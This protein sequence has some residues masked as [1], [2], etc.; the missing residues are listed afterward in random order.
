MK[1]R[2]LFLFLTIICI[3]FSS[4]FSEDDTCPSGMRKTYVDDLN[5]NSYGSARRWLAATCFFQF[6]G[7]LFFS[8]KVLIEPRFEVHYKTAIDAVEIVENS[9]EQKIYGF[10][11]VI[12]GYKNTISGLEA[13]SVAGGT[14]SS[15]KF[16]D[17]GYNNFVNALIIE[18]D[19]NPDDY[20]PGD[21]SFS[22]RYCGTSC[23]SYDSIAQVSKKLTTQAY[24]PGQ[25]NEWD[26]RLVYKEKTLILY[27][28]PNNVLHQMSYDLEAT[29]G[30]NIGYV[31]FT[32]F[33]ESNRGEVNI[34]GTF[35]CED[36]YVIS[37]M[38]GTFYQNGNFY[39]EANY[40][41]GQTINYAFN[42]IDNQ[43][44]KV[45]HTFGY[46]IWEY[47]FY[48]TQDCD[49]KGSYTISK[50]DN[51]TLILTIPACT[52]VGSHSININEDIKGAAPKSYYN[53]VPGPTKQIRLVGHDG[54]IGAVPMK[55]STDIYYLGFGES[56]SGDF[57]IKKD[58]K[59]ILDFQIS[60]QYGNK[61]IISSSDNLFTLK[62]V[63]SD[64]ST[65]NI[66]ANT[67]SYELKE[68]G[69][70]YQMTISVG[71]IG[72]YQ[73]EK[74]EYMDKPIRFDVIP[75]DAS[76]VNSYCELTGYSSAPTVKVGTTLTYRC[77]LRDA[78]GNEISIDSFIQNSKYEFTCSVDKN[79]P[80]QKAFSPAIFSSQSS[81]YDCQYV[82]SEI[83]NFAFNG[84]LKL[85]TTKVT[86]KITSIINQF[87]V[88]GESSKYIIQKILDPSTKNWIDIDTRT[89][90]ITYVPD[91]KGFITAIDFA[92]EDGSVLISSYGSYPSDFN[93]K[94]IA[95]KF[96][97][98]HDESFNFVQPKLKMITLD[99]KP[100]IGVYTKDETSTDLLFKKTSFY[101]NL[102][103]TYNNN[104]KSSA[105]KYI[106]NLSN[107]VTCF[108]N[109]KEENTKV[110]IPDSVTLLTKAKESKIGYLILQTTDNN[111]YNY[112]I[113]KENIK[114]NLKP[115][116][117]N[118]IFRI[119][120]QSTEGVYDIY[121]QSTIDFIGEFEILVNE[122]KVKTI[123]IVSEPPQ[124]C[125]LEWEN[126]KNTIQQ[127]ETIGKEKY[128]EYVGGFDNGN[129]V[130][131]FKLY[132]KYNQIIENK[133]YFSKYADISSEKYGSDTTYFSI[134]YDE[135]DK[136][137]KF[138]DNVPYEKIQQGWIFYTRE[139]TCNNKYYLRYDGS[140]GGSPLSLENSYFTLLNTEIYINYEAFV[141][142]IYKDQNNQL[143]G[144]QGDKLDLAKEKTK[145]TAK[146]EENYEITLNYDTTTSNYA[147]R[148]KAKFTVSGLYKITVKYD[149]TNELKYENS[150]ELNVIDNIYN[151][152]HSKFKMIIGTVVEMSIDTRVTLDNK[153]Y[154]PNFKLEFYSKDDLKTKYDKNIKFELEFKSDTMPQPIIFQVN[155]NNDEFVQFNFPESETD[156]FK[157]LT[158]GDYN[159]ILRD[160]KSNL[161]YPISL[162]GGVD[163]DHSNDKE[164][165]LS[166]TEVRPLSIDGIAGKTYT[167]TIEFRAKDNLRWNYLV[168]LD[169][170]KIEYS[171][172]DLTNEN[173]N[174]KHILGPKKGQVEILVTQ[175]K[176]TT[177][178]PNYLSFKYKNEVIPKKVALTI[179][180]ADLA[181]LELVEGPTAG[182]VIDP[183]IIV[184]R[185][186]DSYGNLYEN[187]FTKSVSKEEL[188]ALTVGTSKDKISLGSNH[189]LKDNEFLVV[190]YTSQVS[191]N[192]IVSSDYFENS[193]TYE[194]RIYSGPIDKDISYAE[195]KST[196][197]DVGGEYILLITPKDLY[198]NDIDGLNEAHLS[199]FAIYYQTIT[200]TFKEKVENCTLVEKSTNND[201]RIL[202]QEEEE[203]IKY[204]NIECRANITKAGMFQFVVYYT[205]F[206][207]SCK[208][209]CQFFVTARDVW[210]SK[211][212]T[213]Y[214]NKNIYLK[215]EEDNE[216]ETETYPV[217]EVSFHDYY[218]NQLE[219]F[220]VN[221][222]NIGAVL[223]GTDIK[224]CVLDEGGKTK[225]IIVCPT[226]NGDDNENKWKYLTNNNYKLMIYEINVQENRLSYPIAIRDGSPDGSSDDPDFTKTYF[227]PKILNLIAGEEG[228]ILMEI[229]TKF[230]QRKN[231][232]YPE[233][234]GKIKINFET[235]SNT[236]SSN[237][238][239]AELPGQ[240]YIKITCTKTTNSNYISVF[241]E[242]QKVP[243]KI[244]LV[245]N[246]GLA[247]YLELENSA[248]FTISSD[249]YT[250]KKN[251]TND[252]IVSFS[253]KFKD[254]YQNYLTN[255]I[256]G[257]NQY[258][259]FSET[260]GSG[261]TYYDLK[262]DQSK[263]NY[264][265][266]DKI[267][268]V[269]SKHTWN[270]YIVE[271][272]RKY[273][274]IYTKVPGVPDLSKSYWKIDKTSY[275]LKETSIVT[276]Y[277]IDRLGV[278][279]GSL[280]NNLDNEKDKVSVKT[281]KGNDIASYTYNSFT[282]EY[283]KYTYTYQNIGNYEV[284]VTYNN[285]NMQEKKD[286][287]VAYQKVDLKT[288][289]LYY[290]ID[291]VN[292]NLM[293]LTA[294]TNINNILYYPFYKFFLY[295]SDGEKITLYDKSVKTTCVMTYSTYT[296]E[297]IVE[298]LDDYIKLSYKPDFREEFS[299]LPLAAYNLEITYGNEILK[300]PLFLLGE[301]D[302][303]PS[304][305]YDLGKI[306]INPIE[307]EAY[308][309]EE[310]EVDIEFR[311][312]DGLRWNYEI[313]LVSFGV[314]NSYNL[315]ETKLQIKK[316][317]GEKNGLMKLKIKQFVTTTGKE[318]NILTL[319]YQ[320]KTITQ[321]I[322]LN[323]KSASLKYI[324][325]SSGLKDG[326][327]INPPILAFIPYDEFGNICTQV[328]DKNEYP[329]NK[330]NALFKGESKE[331]YSLTSNIYTDNAYIYVSYGCTKVTKIDVTSTYF[332]QTY[333]YQ[334]FSG[335]IDS[336]TSYAEIVKI[337]NVIAGDINNIK[338]YPKDKY[339]NDVSSLSDDE[340]SNFEV[341]YTIGGGDSITISGNC[342]KIEGKPIYISCEKNITKSG[343]V[344]FGVDYSDKVVNCINCQFDINP[345]ALDFLKTKVI[346]KN[347][348]K[349]MSKTNI[350]VLSVTINP[351]FVLSFFDRFMNSIINENEV[352]NLGVNT[353]IEITDVKLCVK[354]D[355]L[356]KLSALCDS[357][358]NDENIEK[359]KYVPNGNN[360]KL[361]VYTKTQNLI[362]PVQ[363][364]GG[365]TDGGSGPFDITKTYINPTTLTLTAGVEGSVS[366]ELRTKDNVRKNYWYLDI[367]SHLGVKFPD[368][369]EQCEYTIAQGSKP[370]QYTFKFICT[371]KK[372]SFLTT[373]MV[374][375]QEIPT[376]ITM[377]VIPNE[378]TWSKLFTMEGNEI[379]QRN[380]GSV[381]V[382]DKFQMIN[383]LYDKYNN[384]ITD[385]NFD[386]S[387]LKIKIAPSKEVK[388]YE[389]SAETVSQKS[390][391]ITITLKS[392]YAGEHIVVG[393]YLPLSNYTI[394]FSHGEPNADN[395]I[396]QVSKKEAFVG[397]I[398]K[399]Y[400]TPYDKYFNLIDANEFKDSSP[401]QVKYA[402]EGNTA[403]VI[404]QSHTIEAVEGINVLSYPGQFYV[405]GYT[406]FYGYIDI[407]P[408]KCVSCRI[409]IKSQDLDFKSSYVM[410]YESSK[411]DYEL[412]KDGIIEK[413]TKEEP[414][415]RLYP[416][417][418]YFNIIDFIPEEKLKTFKAY[419]KS[420]L[421]G[422]I[423]NL[424]LNNKENINQKYAEFVINDEQSQSNKYAY[425][426][427][428]YYD[429]VFTDGTN[430][431]KY[432]ISL[433][434]DHGGSNKEEDIQ[435]THINEQN[436]KFIAGDSGYIILE[437]RTIE[438]K[439]KSN[440]DY[441][442]IVKPHGYEDLTFK[443]EQSRAGLIGVFQITITTQKANT[444]P[445]L[446]SCPLDIYVN[447]VLVEGLHPEMEVSPNVVVKTEILKKY[448]KPNSDTELIDGNADNNYIF[449]VASYDQYNNLAET[450][451]ETIG[452]KVTLQGGAEVTKTTSENEIDTGYRKYSVPATKA[453]TY[454]VSTSKY[455]SQGI[456]LRK[457]AHFLIAPGSIDLTKTIIKEKTT[458]I[459]AGNN[460]VISI[461]AFDKNGNQLDYNKYINKFHVMFIDANSKEIE[462]VGKYDSGVKKVFYT[463][464]EPV[465]IV[466]DI[467]VEVTY[468][469]KDK[470]DTSK[471]IIVVIPGDP[472]P[473]NSILSRETSSGVYTEYLN[474]SSFSIDTTQILK[475]N[476][477][478][479][480][481][482]KNYVYELPTNANVADVIMSGNKMKTIT[483]TVLKNTGNFDLDFNSNPS[484]VHIYNHLVKGAYD[485]NL[486]VSSSLGNA[487]FHYKLIVTNGDDLHGNG[488]YVISKCV[489]KPKDTS[490]V[491]GNYEKF[492]LELRTED[493]L[494]YNDDIDI[495]NDL[496][497]NI[498]NTQDNT[499]QSSKSKAGSD[500]GI[501]TIT[502]YS[503]KKGEY[504][505]NVEVTDP[506]SNNKEKKN[507][508][509]A[510][511]KVT[512][513]PIPDKEYTKITAQP[514]ATIPDDRAITI[515][516]ALYDKF[517]NNIEE[518]D[519]IIKISY[520]TLINNKEPYDYKS[521]N[522]HE[523]A[524]LSLMPKYPPKKM[525]LNLLYNNGETTVYI[526]KEDIVLTIESSIDPDKTKIVSSNK[527]KIYAG[528][529][530]DMWIYTLDAN[531]K[532]LDN[533]DLHSQFKIQVTGPLDSTL[534]YIR[535][536]DIYKTQKSTGDDS[537][538]HN[539][540]QIS[541]TNPEKDKY[542]YAGN[543]LIK[544]MYG[545]KTIKQYNQICY[546]LE[547]SKFKL[548]YNFNPDSISILDS[549]SFTVTGM[550]EYNNTVTE[551]L[552]DYFDIS[553]TKN[554]D[555][556][557][558]ETNKK[559]E[560][561]QGTLNYQISI[562][563]VGTHQLHI[564]Y[565]EKEY[566][567]MNK[568]QIDLPKFT[569]LTG[570]CYAEDNS[571]F[572][573]NPLK[574]AEVSVKTHFIFYCYDRFKNKITK[575]GE[576]FTVKAEYLSTTTQG[577]KIPLDDARVID[578]GDGSYNV[579][580]VPTMKGKYFFNILIGKEKYG[581]EVS[582]ELK[583]FTCPSDTYSCPNKRLCVADLSECIDPDSKCT[584]E[585]ANSKDISGT[586]FYCKVNGEYKCVKSQ[587][588]CDCPDGY[589]KCDIMKYCVP[590]NRPDMCP[591]LKG[592]STKCL[593]NNLV[594]NLDGICRTKKS[595]PNQRVCP[596]GKV[597]CADLSCRDNYDECVV[598]EKRS[599]LEF[600]CIGQ[601]IVKDVNKC[602]SS[603]TCKT[604]NKVV[605]QNGECVDNEIYCPGL[606][607][608][609]DNYPYLCQND[610]CAEKFE[611]CAPSISCGENKLLCKD[612]ICRE[613]C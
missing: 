562:H 558:F 469:N 184:F 116:D 396:L 176:V 381:S 128:Y 561:I 199:T 365:Y 389:Y 314:S 369:M 296:W 349:E 22:I 352:K 231:Y 137:Y 394:T 563:T 84:Y 435:K 340:L 361:K 291:N 448:Y 327:V 223:Q 244:Q 104:I 331:K 254:K 115:S 502:I 98:R 452:L 512:P 493:G 534:K 400:I 178:E 313:N 83:G 440:W 173:I 482:W 523:I 532:C 20:D 49:T 183:P 397:E 222:I 106:I 433:I 75:S 177:N 267:Q 286:I 19:F 79:L 510:K 520:F 465:T 604:E 97:S 554:N 196:T 125:Y 549:P 214:T 287:E 255:S 113:G 602:P 366:L 110:N 76:S 404:M 592:S 280:E 55:S 68:N 526:F 503:E 477:T 391:D 105:I 132:D 497:I 39:E 230:E 364:T 197:D 229:R 208:N 33:M 432:N 444:Y 559:I 283:I 270:I 337:E 609:N 285:Q 348:N 468:D 179:K 261:E 228:K 342:K 202:L 578:N 368:D 325:Y 235:D 227:S 303:S 569:I 166:K 357:T 224:L 246:S 355:K 220:I 150:N 277:L 7:S 582:F 514:E 36:N 358:E 165:D 492:T 221:K 273:S 363:I 180:C 86:T 516:F 70:Y 135:N 3:L 147:L 504:N 21:S 172:K 181:N 409:D 249:K 281:K 584:E 399:V 43:G 65:S 589:I 484:Y 56:S 241:I 458:P 536:F 123:T 14:S 57:I 69:K 63:N 515:K 611:A 232:W 252:E 603:I 117:S 439:R 321:T 556:T 319:T 447:N 538:C 278:Y 360:Y 429:L 487:N 425:L 451:Q 324:T 347:N 262:F 52:T 87:Y 457:E 118:I 552:Y 23:H 406:N 149:N 170:F 5:M 454:V 121:A 550:D 470:L 11:I 290:N 213:L 108:H 154:T 528:Q 574:E 145:V 59:I 343:N 472:Y 272:N 436:L 2:N 522:F 155:K 529:Q 490:F 151:L 259:I 408:I 511:Y 126:S 99:F 37:K 427:S 292:D 187:L 499:F 594:Y 329:Q 547:Y 316:I 441:N 96:F 322:S 129:L 279:L 288:S 4:I 380:L 608:C 491:A 587:T 485:L 430:S 567:K 1:E 157:E 161:I 212:K 382:E 359:W 545:G 78:D 378:P 53:V 15:I 24:I 160:E 323:I 81:Y 174:I 403:K 353:D 67:I 299:K 460:P 306:N 310:K 311:A 590:E 144:L 139:S 28:G 269:I 513:D 467:K 274:F 185:P 240:Y 168:N 375:K 71:E 535:E 521:L 236:C 250:W 388:N 464:K 591:Y 216:V 205:R 580:F 560:P 265:F 498:G 268:T 193:I 546:P 156:Y 418:E 195:I 328:F 446:V 565:K 143:F 25:R 317:S 339:K 100:Y 585:R 295:T 16:Q 152:Q 597:L 12:S 494:L 276:V 51:Y 393:A 431:L 568:E 475:L 309:G 505:L 330:L 415:Y 488:D 201:L 426:A 376:K 304:S 203:K 417:D 483:F 167:I 190:Q 481:K 31:G 226:E 206:I 238:E 77:H 171:Q 194:Y 142:V 239:Q 486:K 210:F 351:N 372:D 44:K 410:R 158:R 218:D 72:S 302:V 612:N 45:P 275:I 414:V 392:T 564:F 346:N 354:N 471:I 461:V 542:K 434:N 524:E 420:Q 553:F 576:K 112:D 47:S 606:K 127:K 333:S 41:P 162:I 508:G 455:G 338:I 575:G 540:Y 305:D 581:E 555:K 219:A 243:T 421:E 64:G 225:N 405:R 211:T 289:K 188:E 88:R 489:L 32:G 124:A 13:R 73:I 599:S 548:D 107:Y 253:F 264:L 518:S 258:T 169:E 345:D 424:K 18:F 386:L 462:S 501:Y 445:K 209:Q 533:G 390:G 74:N 449:E 367:T 34:M 9:G 583:E 362:Y 8:R 450:K 260:F 90:M 175:T 509:P 601:Q 544:V 189:Y 119:S 215:T 605:C 573:T 237:V 579:E 247:Y 543:Y 130:V 530:L 371:K 233:P 138:R 385:I 593:V 245:V 91:S 496:N 301:A 453:G 478:L 38:K 401:Y 26:F 103:F 186:L 377:K 379:T 428:G 48:I 46:D 318:N 159:L 133:D 207:I 500:Y 419:L 517:N 29:L 571:N 141:E 111:L 27:S 557:V 595:G 102:E 437:I 320:S 402:N 476:M 294:Q 300:Y 341:H 251:P 596:I 297:L 413:N 204:T 95:V 42:F 438:D 336:S 539:E 412:L 191:T 146:N 153:I 122:I 570:P 479:Y 101:Y 163:S 94:N 120:P 312:S 200:G 541:I 326:T 480:D 474:E 384:L 598:T 80:S 463:S 6:P 282:S 356:N 374:E 423:Y 610:V 109:L 30:T 58:L 35:M 407:N 531:Y 61:V 466:G 344:L 10:T 588:D 266:T 307:I 217:F 586:P 93:I 192:V 537:E 256:K 443:A 50:L 54:I 242:S 114:F 271:S 459:Q 60:D 473:P 17:I 422:I 315:D 62:K 89:T 370:G 293:S 383:K 134:V 507:V 334:L 527:E 506:S 495:N 572:D 551:P 40:E 263:Y 92:E 387:I 350:N 373:I 607:K 600:R 566:Y 148:Y 66:N 82:T 284:S 248:L 140:K 234:N 332:T 411:N 131:G 456:Y 85:K 136:V 335:P 577:D 613:E 308:A 395:S 519:N 164:Y 182:D 442:I 198:N 398:V 525:Y 257:T 298:K 416:R